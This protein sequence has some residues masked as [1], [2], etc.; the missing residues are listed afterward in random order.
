MLKRTVYYIFWLVFLANFLLGCQLSSEKRAEKARESLSSQLEKTNPPSHLTLLLPITGNSSQIG[1]A[2]RD[3]FLAAYYA[4][5]RPAEVLPQV[6]ILDTNQSTDIVALYHQAI[7]G[8]ADFIIGP[9]QADKVERLIRNGP[10]AVPTLVLKMLPQSR[11][12]PKGIYQFSLLQELEAEQLA[13]EAQQAGYLRALVITLNNP[14]GHAVAQS[15]KQ[16]WLEMGG[17]V[18]DELFISPQQELGPAIEK[19]IQPTEVDEELVEPGYDHRGQRLL[20]HRPDVDVLFLIT[21]PNIARQIRPLLKYYYASNLPIYATSLVYDS[22]VSASI[23][24]DLDGVIVC[25]MPWI[26]SGQAKTLPSSQYARFY[27][28][29][30]DAYGIAMT[31]P[32]QTQQWSYRGQTGQLY[33]NQ[34]NQIMR[35]LACLPIKRGKPQRGW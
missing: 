32:T 23:N 17:N 2:I 22:H 12:V 29:G 30:M 13:E 16:R 33:L 28:L 19:L 26:Q 18:V 14:W 34:A 4:E 35:R 10:V 6:T 20:Q 3:G 1:Q 21:P 27:A 11:R 5:R 8:G 9:I 15:L 31:L 25:D 7:A 24:K